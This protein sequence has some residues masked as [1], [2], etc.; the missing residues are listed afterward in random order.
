MPLM[1][2][3]R[4]FYS[5]GSLYFPTVGDNPDIHPYWF[6]AFL[7]NTIMVNGKVWP[8]M[9]VDNGQYRFRLLDASNARVYILSLVNA[10]TNNL[11]P[12]TQI[13][14]DGGYLRTAANITSLT[15]APGERAD[16]L[17]DFS[18][19]S[20]RNQNPAQKQCSGKHKPNRQRPADSRPNYAIHSRGKEWICTQNATCTSKSD[21]DG[22]NI[23]KL[24]FSFERANPYIE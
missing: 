9:N 8:N 22:L 13:G 6:Q 19:M 1:I 4:S 18:N 21:V 17:V 24:A 11:I 5:D 3:D 16:I 20:V 14:S 7:G 15:I 2:Q 10:E 23:P 12:F